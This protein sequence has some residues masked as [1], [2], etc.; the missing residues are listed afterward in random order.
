MLLGAAVE[1]CVL[2]LFISIDDDG[3]ERESLL[4]NRWQCHRR[5]G[6][7]NV[8]HISVYYQQQIDDFISSVSPYD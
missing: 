6:L 1:N 4:F 5:G 3:S 8:T 2:L 7:T